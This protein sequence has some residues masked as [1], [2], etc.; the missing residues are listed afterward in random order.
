MLLWKQEKRADLVGY[1]SDRGLLEDGPLWK[2]AQALFEVLGRDTED[3]K[4]V[5]TLLGERGTLRTEGMRTAAQT[6]LFGGNS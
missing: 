2:L 6:R 1:L 4:L 5:S 3:W